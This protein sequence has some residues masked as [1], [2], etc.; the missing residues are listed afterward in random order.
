MSTLSIHVARRDPESGPGCAKCGAPTRLIGIEPHP[1]QARTDL[2]SFECL[3]CDHV[4][5]EMVVIGA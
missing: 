5:T 3:V 2:R 1:V 4:T